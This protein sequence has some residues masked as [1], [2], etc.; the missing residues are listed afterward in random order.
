MNTLTVLGGSA[1][2]VG[3][4]QG[5]S[6]YLV[7]TA[8]TTLVLDL[9]MD[10]LHE[11]RKQTDFRS[12][13]GIVISHLHMDHV[14]DLFALR[15]TATYN[16]IKP[17]RSLPLFLPPGGLGFMERAA[18]VWYHPNETTPFFACYEMQEYDPTAT[19]T[20]GDVT[21]R[22]AP[23]VH[24]V[25]CWAMRLQTAGS[26]GDLVYTA[27]TAATDDLD[28]FCTGA[29]LMVAD[30]AAPVDA[31]PDSLKARWHC[32]PAQAAAL[33]QRAGARHM[34]VTHVWEENDPLQAVRSAAEVFTGHLTLAKPGITVAW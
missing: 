20:I 21:I 11:L 13:D 9:G 34:V 28:A 7:K 14:L 15:Y 1:A 23:T 24:P 26:D 12:L 10:T 16:P 27:D 5:C 2:G 17:N 33:C 22:F 29:T 32:T 19:L 30:C 3:T 18:A 4:D 6:A 31:E 25:P 8:T